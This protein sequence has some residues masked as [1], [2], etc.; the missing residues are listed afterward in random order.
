MSKT[1]VIG[2]DGA[3]FDL[4]DQWLNEDDLPTMARLMNDGAWQ[5]LRSCYPPVTSPAWRCYS[6]GVNPGKHGVF[7][8]EQFDRK[9]NSITVPISTSYDAKSIWDYLGAEGFTSA[10]VNMPTTHPPEN[11]NGWMVS[12]AGF[13]D[14]YTSPPD[15][16]EELETEI[17]YENNLA[18]P[19]Q[20]ISD[21]PERITEVNGLINKRFEAAK[22]IRENNS[23]DFIHLSIFITNAIQHYVWGGHP[24]KQMWRCIDRNIGELLEEDDNVIIMS[25]H[26]SMKIDTVFHINS[27]L[28]QEG[29]LET[30]RS[31]SSMLYSIGVDK[32][33]LIAYI[34]KL[35]LKG[36]ARSLTPEQLKKLVP[37]AQGGVGRDSKE[38][39][40]DWG[41]S[42]AF[43]SGQGPIY[44]LA[45]GAKKERIKAEIKS[46]LEEIT[47]PGGTIIA[48]NVFEAPEVYEG[49]YVDDGP[50]LVI[51]QA[52]GVHIPDV[53]GSSDV[54]VN[55]DDWKWESENHRN[56]IFI[57]HGPDIDDTG[58]LDS[59]PTLYDLVPTILHW[60]GLSVPDN[61]DGGVIQQIFKNDTIPGTRDVEYS[62]DNIH[63]KDHR[64]QNESDDEMINR[65]KNLG[66]LSN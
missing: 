25:D 61:L 63:K 38:D 54:F 19:K 44:V 12:G 53:V 8:W 2:L 15:L 32:E 35:G 27:W 7:W 49:P 57:T 28:E 65:L 29:Y 51:D 47:D 60:Y 20:S 6:T 36:V 4:L 10:V 22:Y 3:G 56:G 50:D 24:L 66:Y 48:R 41:E 39:I 16:K 34:E 62:G 33:S 40:I 37:G 9:S 13:E 64:C 55:S 59:Q 58:K 26:G 14:K 52:N 5:K 43:A 23:P 45:E 1:I 31:M 42:V 17:G 11:I 30:K 21:D 46:K 18:V